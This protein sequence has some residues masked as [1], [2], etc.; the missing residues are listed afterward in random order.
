M[1]LVEGIDGHGH[2][3]A[4]SAGNLSPH[5]LFPTIGCRPLFS[6]CFSHCNYV[7]QCLLDGAGFSA[8]VFHR[9]RVL[10]GGVDIPMNLHTPRQFF[11]QPLAFAWS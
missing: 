1:G 6:A 5:L 8:V 9:V 4:V 11:Q 7:F 2:D 3:Q 10:P